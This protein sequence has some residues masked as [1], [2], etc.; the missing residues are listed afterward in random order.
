LLFDDAGHRMIP[1]HPTK[2]GIRYRYYVPTPFLHGEE[3]RVGR[4]GFRVPADIED[5]VVKFLKEHLAPNQGKSATGTIPLGNRS[6]LAELVTGVV[7]HWDRLIVR[8]QS[9][10]ADE[11]SDFQDDRSLT[12]PWQT[13]EEGKKRAPRIDLAA[14]H[15]SDG[16][17]SVRFYEAKMAS[18]S[19]LRQNSK[20][21]P[22]IVE[23]FCHRDLFVDVPGSAC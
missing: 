1:T 2:A 17:I 14:L 9:D 11:P 23:C 20:G 6:D 21:E 3:D 22:E 8:L 16:K 12:I 19:R 7:V 10:N 18:D 4:V 5:I 15:N 13:D